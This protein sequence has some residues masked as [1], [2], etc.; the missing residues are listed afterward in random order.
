M[1]STTMV[2]LSWLWRQDLLCVHLIHTQLVYEFYL[3]WILPEVL[4]SLFSGDWGLLERHTRH[5]L[6]R[7]FRLDDSRLR[8]CMLSFYHPVFQKNILAC[9]W[10]PRRAQIALNPQ[11]PKIKCF[12]ALRCA[13][14]W[15]DDPR[16]PVAERMP[17]GRSRHIKV[18]LDE[19]GGHLPLLW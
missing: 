5:R 3:V 19:P 18:G 6:L 14:V 12:V 4:F 2:L 1:A 17:A 13:V 7:E 11:A 15:K 10:V 8:P 16:S 9:V